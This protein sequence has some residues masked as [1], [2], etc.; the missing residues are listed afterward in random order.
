MPMPENTF[1][2]EANILSISDSRKLICIL[3]QSKLEKNHLESFI[4][5]EERKIDNKK[6]ESEVKVQEIQG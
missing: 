6:L 4:K 2:P 3:S 5:D 1:W